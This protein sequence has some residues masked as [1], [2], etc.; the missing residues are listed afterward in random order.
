MLSS[1]GCWAMFSEIMTREFSEIKYWQAH[2]FTVDA[3]ALQHVGNKDD[4][5]DLNSVHI[6]FAALFGIFEK[7][8]SL[9]NAPEL[10]KQFSL[11][12]KGKDILDWL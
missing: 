8:V 2:Q 6:H 10:R 4:K 11:F 1:P 12:Y 9:Q 5:R 7:G 3:Y